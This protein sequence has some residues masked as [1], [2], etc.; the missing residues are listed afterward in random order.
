MKSSLTSQLIGVLVLA[1]W[2]LTTL[3][4]IRVV[5]KEGPLFPFSDDWAIVPQITGIRPV[6]AGWLWAQH[7]DHR[8]PIPK[9][10]FVAMV[11]A[12]KGDYRGE[13][14]GNI[15]LLSISSGLALYALWKIRGKLC[16][17]DA[18]IPLSLLCLDQAA[19]FWGFHFQFT[20]A[21]TLFVCFT[22][23]MLCQPRELRGAW[24][25]FG[26]GC[27]LLFPLQGMNALFCA[28]AFGAYLTFRALLQFP[29]DRWLNRG[30]SEE[31]LRKNRFYA[32]LSLSAVFL[33]AGLVVANFI[34][35]KANPAV[36]HAPAS[37][38]LQTLLRIFSTSLGGIAAAAYQPYLA[39]SL[40]ILTGG[41]VYIALRAA[42]K[43][44]QDLI[45]RLRALSILVLLVTVCALLVVVAYGRAAIWNEG[46]Y[47]HYSTLAEI[48]MVAAYLS[49]ALISS[50]SIQR[51]VPTLLLLGLLGLNAFYAKI[52]H[53]YGQNHRM[54]LAKVWFEMQSGT[55]A[56]VLAE[57]YAKIL[58]FDESSKARA[59]I[60]Y[61]IVELRRAGFE[62]Y[63]PPVKEEAADPQAIDAIF[64]P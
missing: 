10:Y 47:T 28:P 50:I 37:N 49:Y 59:A 17:T 1:G 54:D 15:V 61:G 19:I 16:L 12:F 35:Y 31:Q 30:I 56:S 3:F 29:R 22:V 2:L 44:D 7:N 57:R 45:I 48:V 62:L 46:M 55:S 8:I 43:E 36:G 26:A 40:V 27:L 9:L 60:Q 6:N 33:C 21:T 14:M 63:G 4:A 58:F 23:A 20:G 18:V 25:V 52:F 38:F 42:L 11:R 24:A 64:A 13:I 32:G 51:V 5:W 53:A 41:A 39:I 34:H